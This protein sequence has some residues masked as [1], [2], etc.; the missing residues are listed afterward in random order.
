[1]KRPQSNQ[2]PLLVVPVEKQRQIQEEV[3][4]QLYRVPNEDEL[5]KEFEEVQKAQ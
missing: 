4:K 2:N 3:Q 5:S 1:M